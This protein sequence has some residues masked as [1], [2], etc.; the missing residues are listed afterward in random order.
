MRGTLIRGRAAI[1]SLAD[2]IIDIN[3]ISL[4]DN[5]LV[6][7]LLIKTS[8]AEK[9]IISKIVDKIPR[10]AMLKKLLKNCAFLI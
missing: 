9:R 5:I 8:T 10:N 1:G 3:R 2:M 7:E 6:I 4:K